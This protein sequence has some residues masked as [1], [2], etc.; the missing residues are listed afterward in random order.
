VQLPE[1][2]VPPPAGALHVTVPVGVGPLPLTVAV[3]FVAVPDWA[4]FGVQLAAVV[5]EV[6]RK[7]IVTDGV[8]VLSAVAETPLPPVATKLEPPPPPPPAP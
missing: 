3:Q 5:V 6:E 2:K 1:L 8:P 7:V 4:G